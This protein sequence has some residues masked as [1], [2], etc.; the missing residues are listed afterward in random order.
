MN[1]EVKKTTTEFKKT[2]EET[3]E[4]KELVEEAIKKI[5]FRKIIR[6]GLR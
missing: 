4:D 3:S 1:E 5:F 2:L 6:K